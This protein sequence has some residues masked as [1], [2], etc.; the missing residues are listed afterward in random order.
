MSIETR[1][2][3]NILVVSS[4][5]VPVEDI[6]DA[7]IDRKNLDWICNR[8]PVSVDEV[9]E[10]IDCIAD[11]AKA[12]TFTGGITLLNTGNDVDL[13]IETVSVNDTVYFALISY[14]HGIKPSA[15][16]FDEIYNIGLVNVI[17]DIYQD[18]A[19]G[20]KYFESS[21]LHITVYEALLAEVGDLDPHHILASL[22][23][24]TE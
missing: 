15:L 12:S 23:G 20:A 22:K 8:F 11:S 19:Q 10:C 16:S 4:S 6:T 2:H 3:N 7:V 18:L 9:F 24:D 21:D 17:R 14:G 13:D 5:A 1:G